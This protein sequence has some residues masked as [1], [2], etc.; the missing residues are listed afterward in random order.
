MAAGKTLERLRAPLMSAQPLA[1]IRDAKI[2]KKA[3]QS[4]RRLLDHEEEPHIHGAMPD[5]VIDKKLDAI[6]HPDQ[7]HAAAIVAA[8][9]REFDMPRATLQAVK[10]NKRRDH[11]ESARLRPLHGI[12]N[13]AVLLLD[14]T[15][16]PARPQAPPANP[17]Q[18]I[19]AIDR[20]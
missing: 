14:G 9:L 6:D 12:K 11:I 4:L 8:V 15:G 13:T 18:Q 10:Y 7:R 5:A 20:H 1:A 16:D 3:L 17:R 19:P 2:D